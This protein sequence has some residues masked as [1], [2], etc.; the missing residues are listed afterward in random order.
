[1]SKVSTYI[2]V[3]PIIPNDENP[4]VSCFKLWGKLAEDVGA[5][6]CSIVGIEDILNLPYKTEFTKHQIIQLCL[7]KLDGKFIQVHACIL[8]N[9]DAAVSGLVSYPEDAHECSLV[10]WYPMESE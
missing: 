10:A 8:I 5:E 4:I 1:M 9:E 7:M 2:E 6:Y 3:I